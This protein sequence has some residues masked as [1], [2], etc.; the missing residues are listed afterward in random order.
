MPMTPW[1]T[2]TR[3]TH[4]TGRLRPKVQDNSRITI[5]GPRRGVTTVGLQ[6][7]VACEEARTEAHR[8]PIEAEWSRNVYWRDATPLDMSDPALRWFIDNAARTDD[9]RSH[10]VA[11]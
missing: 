10:E 6:V 2:H 5:F 8:D 11:A 1:R 9:T 4:L 7:E 3:N